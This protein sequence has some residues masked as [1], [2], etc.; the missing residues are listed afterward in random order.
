MKATILILVTLWLTLPQNTDRSGQPAAHDESRFDVPPPREPIS[1]GAAK[2]AALLERSPYRPQVFSRDFHATKA[3]DEAELTRVMEYQRALL[4]RRYDLSDRPS[5]VMMS[6][7]RRA[8]QEGVRVRLPNG[9]TWEQLAG[10][11]PDEIRERGVFPRGFLPRTP[12]SSSTSSSGHDSPQRRSEIWSR[13]SEPYD[14]E[15]E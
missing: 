2:D 12:W 15:R 7:G 11:T 3:E 13:F 10:M 6:G 4:E 8:V 14:P 5:P 9:V 1:D